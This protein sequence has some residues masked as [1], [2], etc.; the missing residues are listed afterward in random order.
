M[1]RH[2]ALIKLSKDHY[3]GLVLAQMIKK[4]APQ[5]KGMPGTLEGKVEYTLTFWQQELTNHF[6]DEENIL[7]PFV[8][9]KNSDLDLL[10]NTMIDEHKQIKELIEKLKLGN[11]EEEILN[12]LGFLL[13]RHIRMEERE[14][15]ETIQKVLSEEELSELILK[16]TDK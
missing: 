13:E 3:H 8:I 4:G 6:E 14:M 15:F 5:Y 7:L 11:N 16:F 1:K 10:L 12:D 9:N 2:Q